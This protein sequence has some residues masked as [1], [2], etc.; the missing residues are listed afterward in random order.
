MKR[1]LL[2]MCAVLVSCGQPFK[3]PDLI[4]R[5]LG[6]GQNDVPR[7]SLGEYPNDGGTFEIP[8][9]SCCVVRFAVAARGEAAVELFGFAPPLDQPIAMTL[10]GGAWQA[11]AC[12]GLNESP[13]GFRA[14]VPT[15]DDAGVFAII[16]TNPNAPQLATEEYGVLNVFSPG[17][18]LTCDALDTAA[19]VDL[20]ETDAGLLIDEDAGS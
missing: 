4:E 20:R 9:A 12:M 3:A 11:E 19:Y 17:D 10:D 14:W 5:D 2:T 1:A 7:G 15:D 13:Y 16:E 6:D 18:A 8:D